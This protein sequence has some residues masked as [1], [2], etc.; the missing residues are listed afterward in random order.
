MTIELIGHVQKMEHSSGDTVLMTFT[1]ETARTLA[2]L[3]VY[4]SKGEVSEYRPGT[5]IKLQ[6]RP[7][8]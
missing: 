7:A 4:A 1:L 3:Q 2:P 6:I 8:P 5:V